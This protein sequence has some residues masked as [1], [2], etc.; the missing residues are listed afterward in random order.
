MNNYVYTAEES[1]YYGKKLF[2]LIS[3]G[4]LKIRIYEEYPFTR[5]GVQKAQSDLTGGKTQGKLVIKVA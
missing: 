1:Y 4:S 5:E 2:E 3:D